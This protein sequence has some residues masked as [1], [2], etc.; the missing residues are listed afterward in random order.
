MLTGILFTGLILADD[1]EDAATTKKLLGVWELTKS[2]V[3][4]EAAGNMTAEFTKDGKITLRGKLAEKKINAAGTFQVKA[5]TITTTIDYGVGIAKSETGKIKKL[6]EKEL[7][8]EDDK[9]KVDKYKRKK[10]P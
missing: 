2:D 8:I 10:A 4:P 3:L 5:N 6:T 9:G 1:N 7:I